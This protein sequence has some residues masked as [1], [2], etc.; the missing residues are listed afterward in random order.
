M[1]GASLGFIFLALVF[2]LPRALP[3]AKGSRFHHLVEN[4]LLG[5]DAENLSPWSRQDHGALREPGHL[6]PACLPRCWEAQWRSRAN[7]N[8]ED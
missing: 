2:L 7:R 6:L 8:S 4:V 1:R 3:E 5:Q